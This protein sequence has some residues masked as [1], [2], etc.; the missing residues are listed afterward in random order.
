[1]DEEKVFLLTWEA[2]FT[3]KC[4]FHFHFH[5]LK[6]QRE[7]CQGH[8][9]SVSHLSLKFKTSYMTCRSSSCS[10]A[11]RNPREIT[12]SLTFVCREP[13]CIK[14]TILHSGS[15][16]S[17]TVTSICIQRGTL[18]LSPSAI[19]PSN[20]VFMTQAFAFWYVIP[21]LFNSSQ[22]GV[23]SVMSQFKEWRRETKEECMCHEF[24]SLSFHSLSCHAY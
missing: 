23:S 6:P 20:E 15:S 4:F 22:A 18:G 12:I 9:P 11:A 17:S 1:M 8:K 3:A 19:H 24:H 14:N 21:T 16:S 2:I 13:S 10:T 5:I 7:D